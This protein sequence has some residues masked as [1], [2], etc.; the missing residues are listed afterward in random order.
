VL[1]TKV[2]IFTQNFNK[3]LIMKKVILAF[4]AMFALTIASFA[5]TAAPT[6]AQTPAKVK[7]HGKETKDHP[8]KGMDEKTKGQGQGMG[9]NLGLSADQQAQYGA[10][11]KAHQE[12]VRKVQ[13]DNTLA[14]EAKKTQVA[15]LKSKYE[16]DLK[17]VMNADQ[18][19]KWSEQRAKRAEN[20]A[21]EKMGDH[22]GGNHKAEGG[23][24]KMGDKKPKAKSDK[25]QPQGAS[26]N[27]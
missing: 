10:I 26:K 2:Y 24:H 22:K 12:A 1:V 19:A 8:R 14:P 4:S 7:G 16:T 25:A 5:Q 11:N 20:K 13:M 15:A 17:G 21:G 9:A 18:Y 23:E 3:N 27:N 6:P